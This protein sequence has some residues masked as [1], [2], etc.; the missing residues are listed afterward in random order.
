MGVGSVQ[1]LSGCGVCTSDLWVDG[2]LGK[3]VCE[4]VGGWEGKGFPHLLRRLLGFLH[5]LEQVGGLGAGYVCS[6]EWVGI[7]MDI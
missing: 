7:W 2:Q 4:W 5:Q 3:W 6:D 1:Q